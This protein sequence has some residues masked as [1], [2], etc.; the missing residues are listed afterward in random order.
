[1]EK[2]FSKRDN[3]LDILKGIGIFLVVMGHTTKGAS[4][5][6]IYMFHMPLFFIVSGCLY[7]IGKDGTVK[8]KARGIVRPYFVFSL[9]SFLYW[10]LLEMRFRPTDG[11]MIDSGLLAGL[12]VPA[13]QFANIFLAANFENGFLYNVPLWFL[14]CLFI[15]HAIYHWLNKFN[16]YYEVGGILLILIFYAAHGKPYFAIG[17]PNNAGR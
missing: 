1:M 7:A 3:V 11:K 9:L 12:S 10:W 2:A 15:A 6:W 5:H 17:F 16:V 13:Q 8:G 4:A 14:P